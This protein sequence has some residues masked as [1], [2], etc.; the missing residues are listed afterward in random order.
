MEAATFEQEIIEKF[1]QL[2]SVQKQ[3]VR[4]FIDF[5]LSKQATRPDAHQLALLNVSIWDEQAI[6]KIEAVQQE[7]NE[8]KL[9]VF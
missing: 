8:W 7:I 1:G 5:L 6:Q 9:A 4:E 3:T 2:T